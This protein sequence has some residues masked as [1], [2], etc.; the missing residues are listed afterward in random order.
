M[1]SL[2]TQLDGV[3]KPKRKQLPRGSH[4]QYVTKRG[5]MVQLNISLPL[6]LIERLD[7]KLMH[8]RTTR[9]YAIEQTIE[10]CLKNMP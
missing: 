4:R 1:K 8:G 5:L 3:A 9:G 7:F 10:H 6:D 2:T